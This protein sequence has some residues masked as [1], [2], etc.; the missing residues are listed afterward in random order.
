M[1][2]FNKGN[3]EVLSH[4]KATKSSFYPQCRIDT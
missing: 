2:T 4:N 3:L 1:K